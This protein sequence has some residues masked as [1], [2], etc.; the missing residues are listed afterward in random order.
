MLNHTFLIHGN[1]WP[2]SHPQFLLSKTLLLLITY[3]CVFILKKWLN[4]GGNNWIKWMTLEKCCWITYS[5]QGSIRN[6][7][8]SL[9]VSLEFSE[10]GHI[11]IYLYDKDLFFLFPLCISS[12]RCLHN[13]FSYYCFDSHFMFLQWGHSLSSQ[14]E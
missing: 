10:G 14:S 2:H 12:I 1:T 4:I 5:L 8:I 9:Y 7:N 3:Y 6:M 11:C 13:F